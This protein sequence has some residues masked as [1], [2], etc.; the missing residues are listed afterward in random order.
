MFTPLKYMRKICL[1]ESH[2]RFRN[3]GD[4]LISKTRFGH[5][6]M[7]T[8]RHWGQKSLMLKDLTK[9]SWHK[10]DIVFCGSFEPLVEDKHHIP[11]P[12]TQEITEVP[13]E[14]KWWLDMG[15]V[16]GRKTHFSREQKRLIMTLEIS[17]G[18][19]ASW[20]CPLW[21]LEWLSL[22]SVLWKSL[23]SGATVPLLNL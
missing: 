14:R 22:L 10:H 15:L 16:V 5:A 13:K 23:V 8:F 18:N 12:A 4:L 19:S 2:F 20:E 3:T 7:D 21:A 17:T 1:T 11:A 9:S 6:L